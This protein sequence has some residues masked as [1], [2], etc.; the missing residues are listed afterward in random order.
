MRGI[1]AVMPPLAWG[2]ATFLVSW[3]DLPFLLL[4]SI[5]V[6]IVW[7]LVDTSKA[8]LGWGG[9]ALAQG[10]RMSGAGLRGHRVDER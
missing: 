2:G 1:C 9:D 4:P 10:A 7:I 8:A 3:D 6:H 5:A